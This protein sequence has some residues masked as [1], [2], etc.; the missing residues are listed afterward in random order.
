ME[1]KVQAGVPLIA[2]AF[3]QD[4][5]KTEKM[6]AWTGRLVDLEGGL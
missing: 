2:V 6:D 3:L 5:K 4:T 1:S